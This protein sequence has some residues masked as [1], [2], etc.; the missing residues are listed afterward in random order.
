[1]AGLH[2]PEGKEKTRFRHTSIRN[3]LHDENVVGLETR[4]MQTGRYTQEK[5]AMLPKGELVTVNEPLRMRDVDNAKTPRGH[6]FKGKNRKERR[7]AK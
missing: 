7:A 4:P 5:A 1:M 2:L 3:R 6:L